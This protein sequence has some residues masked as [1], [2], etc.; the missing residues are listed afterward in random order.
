MSPKKLLLPLLEAWD[1]RCGDDIASAR[2]VV[3]DGIEQKR[4]QVKSR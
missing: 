1:R 2:R 4:R 3:G